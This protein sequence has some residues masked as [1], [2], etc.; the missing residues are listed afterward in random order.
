[1]SLNTDQ[2]SGRCASIKA[3][4]IVKQ[5]RI[6]AVS[7]ERAKSRSY[8]AAVKIK[9]AVPRAR[10]PYKPSQVVAIEGE[11]ECPEVAVAEDRGIQL[12]ASL[13]I[14]T[15]GDT[16]PSSGGQLSTLRTA[17]VTGSR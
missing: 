3:A 13:V 4:E 7:R 12:I 2:C 6:P 11:R 9:F 14:E 16:R 10:L 17:P 15:F 1:M 8:E 5:A